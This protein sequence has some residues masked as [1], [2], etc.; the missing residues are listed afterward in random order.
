MPRNGCTTV[1]A[2]RVVR[3]ACPLGGHKAVKAVA[4]AT[5]A[6]ICL[7]TLGACGGSAIGQATPPQPAPIAVAGRAFATV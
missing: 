3:S 6:V 7:R 1:Q 5:G 4:A 2:A